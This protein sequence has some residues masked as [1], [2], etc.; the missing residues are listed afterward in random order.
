MAPL[1]PSR[2]STMTG[3]PSFSESFFP[4]RRATG[5]AAEPAGN[6]TMMWI[7]RSG[8]AAAHAPSVNA[9]RA[10]VSIDTAAASVARTLIVFSKT[11]FAG[12]YISGRGRHSMEIY[13]FMNELLATEF[14]R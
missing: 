12:N 2:L 9:G 6:G 1:A 8:Q 13:E 10:A 5:S 11:E 14:R 7:G 4:T 3:C